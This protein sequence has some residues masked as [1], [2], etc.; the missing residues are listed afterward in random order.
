MPPFSAMA[1]LA[2]FALVLGA[3]AGQAPAPRT[4]ASAPPV[5]EAQAS[6]PEAAKPRR[7]RTDTGCRVVRGDLPMDRK[8][9][10][11]EQFAAEQGGAGQAAGDTLL[12][13]PRPDACRQ[14]A[15]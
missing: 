13:P 9:A 10:L 4:A 8:V 1:L 7:R 12:P 6:T 3:C 2:A 14:A 5:V 11:F 15:R